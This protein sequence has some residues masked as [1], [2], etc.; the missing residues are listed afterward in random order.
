MTLEDFEKAQMVKDA[1]STN[2]SVNY[3]VFLFPSFQTIYLI[4]HL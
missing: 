2:Y 4:A 1:K 3:I